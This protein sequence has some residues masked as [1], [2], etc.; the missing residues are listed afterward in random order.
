MTRVLIADD[1]DTLIRAGLAEL[2]AADPTV[3]LVGEAAT[4]REAVERAKRLAPDIVFMDVRIPDLDGIEATRALTAELPDVKVVI[5]TT[6]EQDDYLFGA[7]R[8]GL[9]ASCSSACGRRS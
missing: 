9:P 1:D 3:V 5:L 7:L 8:A 2:L 4:G 6:F